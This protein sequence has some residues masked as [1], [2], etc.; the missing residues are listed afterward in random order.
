MTNTDLVRWNG[1]V[2]RPRQTLKWVLEKNPNQFTLLTFIFFVGVFKEIS[3]AKPENYSEANNIINFLFTVIL[4]GGLMQ[5][6]T[7]SLFIWGINFCSSWFG[8]EGNF[9]RMQIALTWTLFL[10]FISS[11][12]LTIFAYCFFDSYIFFAELPF[13]YQRDFSLTYKSVYAIL[14][15]ILVSWYIALTIIAISEVQK[16]SIWQSLSSLVCGLLII[17]VP[18]AII[19]LATNPRLWYGT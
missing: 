19:T 3:K 14:N 2:T 6:V 4:Q 11:F 18:L 16:L 9:K 15:I 1:I 13:I 10:M 7:F 17:I 8:G 5:V 12:V